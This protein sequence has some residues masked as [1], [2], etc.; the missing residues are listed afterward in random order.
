ML[1]KGGSAAHVAAPSTSTAVLLSSQHSLTQ[2]G[3][4][5]YD[6]A[7]VEHTPAAFT[8]LLW[9]THHS[10]PHH[11][12]RSTPT[13]QTGEPMRG[14]CCTTAECCGALCLLHVTPATIATTT[15]PA[16]KPAQ[17]RPQTPPKHPFQCQPP[18]RLRGSTSY[19]SVELRQGM[20]H[21]SLYI[22]M[23]RVVGSDGCAAIHTNMPINPPQPS[24]HDSACMEAVLVQP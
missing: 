13:P 2:V 1:N 6:G 3:R 9:P 19:A 15:T 17:P 18:W 11:T 10:I 22:C 23:C 12:T 8:P 20:Q 4:H 21:L 16:A 7:A 24:N 5:R 14:C